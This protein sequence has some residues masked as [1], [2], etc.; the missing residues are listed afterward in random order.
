MVRRYLIINEVAKYYRMIDQI[1]P[2]SVWKYFN[3][4]SSIPR[5]SKYEQKIQQYLIDFA[6]RNELTWKQ[7][8]VGN[9][10]IIKKTLKKDST[11]ETIALQ[12]HIDMVCEKNSEIQ[13]DFFNDPIKLLNKDNWI[14]AD[15]TTL[16]ADNGVGVA[17]QLAILSSKEDFSRDI[18]CL[19]TVDEETGLTGAFGL[20]KDFLSAPLMINLDSEQDDEIFVGC[21][22]GCD[23]TAIFDI[24]QQ[25]VP[26][27]LFF[28]DVHI[29]GLKGGHSGDDIDKR[30]ANANKLLNDYLLRIYEKYTIWI[31]EIRGGSL[32]NAIPR[33]SYA[34]CAVPRK[35]K[36][37]VR[38]D[39]NIF[40]ADVEEEWLKDEPNMK[41]YLNSCDAFASGWESTVVLKDFLH[42][43]SAC[44]HGVVSMSDKL[45]G[46]VQ[47]STN[48]ASISSNKTQITVATNQRSLIE[49]ERDNLAQHI[50]QIFEICGA[51]ATT[52]NQYPGWEPKFDSYLLKHSSEVYE[53]LFLE[54]P[55]IRVI[56]AG[57]ECGVIAGTY[58]QMDIIS[59][60]PTILDAHSPSERV[61]ILSVQKIWEF[62][63]AII[64]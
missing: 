5:P 12:S 23:T 60:G 6:K 64:K 47:T 10:L 30:R 56:H 24:E 4:I 59:I 25:E 39:W 20:E 18:E 62:L 21:A 53:Q 38:V 58:P 8:E 9:I 43:I 35:Y 42:S 49:A 37:L 40:I 52:N 54:K 44:P 26:S 61:S 36:E 7:D 15:G 27:E 41:F 57:L 50:C 63:L 55:K 19:F 14:T 45:N 29:C 11:K 3:E 16:G 28:F 31:G 13:H 33:E 17:F 48:L 34:T 2:H 22:G 51:K 46:T 1:H 32:R